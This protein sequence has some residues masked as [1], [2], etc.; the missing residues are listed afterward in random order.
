VTVALI[1]IGVI[2]F[3]AIDAYIIS[4]VL[5]RHRAPDDYRSP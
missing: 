2:A 4:R 1:V 3:L 5:R